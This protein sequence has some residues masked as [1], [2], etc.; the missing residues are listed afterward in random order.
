MR[1]DRRADWHIYDARQIA[2]RFGAN[3]VRRFI[4]YLVDPAVAAPDIE[5]GGVAEG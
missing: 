1:E 2:Y 5:L 4:E 3:H